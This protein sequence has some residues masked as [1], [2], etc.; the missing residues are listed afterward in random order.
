MFHTLKTLGKCLIILSVV[1]TALFTPIAFS[2]ELEN[3]PM[4]IQ[5]PQTFA[6]WLEEDFH[7][8]LELP[9]KWQTPQETID[10]KAGD[11][12]D[13]ALLASAFLNQMGIPND[14]VI[15]KFAGLNVSHAICLWKDGTGSY[16]FISDRKLQ[17]TGEPDI[18]KAIGKFYPDCKKIIFSDSS[19]RFRKE[20]VRN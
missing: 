10:S 17:L 1:T 7:Y 2:K 3:I 4:S 15:L 20:L 16:N 19:K 12:E 11:C 6:T 14:V 9:D 5:N 13:F 8:R 18:K